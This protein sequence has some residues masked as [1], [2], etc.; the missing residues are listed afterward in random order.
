M[1][2]D[3]DGGVD[4]SQDGAFVQISNSCPNGAQHQ[5]TLDSCDSTLRTF[6]GCKKTGACTINGLGA[7]V[8]PKCKGRPYSSDHITCGPGD[9]STDDPTCSYK[10]MDAHGLDGCD[11]AWFD[12]G[13][14][15]QQGLDQ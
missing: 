5:N 8:A 4:A 11:I 7:K 3:I 12:D 1:D 13:C 2:S 15:D 6:F 10:D 14:K 9:D